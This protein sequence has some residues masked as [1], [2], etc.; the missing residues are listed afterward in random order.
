MMVVVIPTVPGSGVFTV[1][2]YRV[3]FEEWV[4]LV[5]MVPL[6]GT[7]VR[8]LLFIPRERAAPRALV[9]QPD[10]W[11]SLCS[12]VQ[13]CRRGEWV[14]ANSATQCPYGHPRIGR[15]LNI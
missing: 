13:S 12:H 4:L 11:H 7:N 2:L 9:S 1:Q 6:W 15:W 3:L 8:R 5:L 14:L 10:L